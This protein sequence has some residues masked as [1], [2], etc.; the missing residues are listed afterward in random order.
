M[1]AEGR[2]WPQTLWRV[3]WGLLAT[4]VFHVGALLVT[5][6][7]VTGPASLRKPLTFA[8]TGWLTAFALVAIVL[9]GAYASMLRALVWRK[10]T[11]P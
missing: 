6:G 8:E 1:D 4:L 3:G 5:G 2:G 9:L 7:P 10:E 11:L